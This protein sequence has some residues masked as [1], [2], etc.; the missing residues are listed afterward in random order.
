MRVRAAAVSYLRIGIRSYQPDLSGSGFIN[1]GFKFPILPIS[2]EPQVV[3]V[4]D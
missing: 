1:N 2:V 3:N 4:L